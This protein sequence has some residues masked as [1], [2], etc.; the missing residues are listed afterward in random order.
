MNSEVD[1]LG[2]HFFAD[3]GVTISYRM[4]QNVRYL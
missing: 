1:L 2:F 4:R 3:S